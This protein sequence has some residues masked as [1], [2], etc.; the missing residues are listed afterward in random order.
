MHV[1]EWAQLGLCPLPAL[2][3]ETLICSP[4]CIYNLKT[5]LPRKGLRL[6]SPIPTLALVTSHPQRQP[7]EDRTELEGDV[8]SALARRTEG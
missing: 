2:T 7:V 1:P 3:S 8:E 6:S 4:K 5:R